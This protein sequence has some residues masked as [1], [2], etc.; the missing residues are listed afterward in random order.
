ML[1]A[2]ENNRVGFDSK[3]VFLK[4]RMSYSWSAACQFYSFLNFRCSS[5][6]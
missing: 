5:K 4:R 1:Q 6:M 3:H 2:T